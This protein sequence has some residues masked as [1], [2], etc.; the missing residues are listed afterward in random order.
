MI[1]IGLEILVESLPT[2]FGRSRL[3]GLRDPDPVMRAMQ[4]DERQKKRVFSLR[5]TWTDRCQST[6]K[7]FTNGR[8]S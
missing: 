4:I 1:E 3:D 2:L 8:R 7:R 5:P 6:F